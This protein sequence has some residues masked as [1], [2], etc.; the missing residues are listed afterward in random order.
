MG[1]MGVWQHG[2]DM[3][4]ALGRQRRGV[5]ISVLS[6]LPSV[7]VA[8]SGMA[9]FKALQRHHPIRSDVEREG[10]EWRSK[11]IYW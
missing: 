2:C 1:A 3:G 4:R 5:S 9:G 7:S 11:L 8:Q 10:V 6:A